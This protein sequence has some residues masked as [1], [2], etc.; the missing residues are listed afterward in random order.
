MN[1]PG[2]D[3]KGSRGKVFVFQFLLEQAEHHA[4]IYFPQRVKSTTTFSNQAK[5]KAFKTAAVTYSNKLSKT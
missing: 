2:T 3:Q 5:P 4:V 1:L